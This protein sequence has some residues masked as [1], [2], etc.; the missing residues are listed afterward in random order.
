[1]E[2]REEIRLAIDD[3]I[4]A[5]MYENNNSERYYV[6]S[7]RNRLNDICEDTLDHLRAKIQDIAYKIEEDILDGIDSDEFDNAYDE[8]DNAVQKERERD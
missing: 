1:M 7:A 2:N 8:F 5:L 3:L 4:C 6:E